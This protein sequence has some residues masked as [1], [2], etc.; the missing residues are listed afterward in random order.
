MRPD[1]GALIVPQ[2]PALPTMLCC[3]SV[4]ERF[5]GSVDNI[6]I[7]GFLIGVLDLI[8]RILEYVMVNLA[9]GVHM[10]TAWVRLYR[11]VHLICALFFHPNIIAIYQRGAL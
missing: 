10:S 7:Y 3:S 11:S 4:C 6:F 8:W 1:K 2:G 9:H 5:S